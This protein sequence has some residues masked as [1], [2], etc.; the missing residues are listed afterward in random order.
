MARLIS[1]Q[2]AARLLDVHPQTV[3]NWV[4]KGIIKGHTVDKCLMVDRDTIEQYFDSLQDLAHLEKTVKE[5]TE[6]LREEDFN[7]QFEID[8]L[9]EAHDR[10]KDGPRGYYRWVSQYATMSAHGLF[11]GQQ[12]TIFHKMMNMGSAELVAKELGISRSRVVDIF[13]KCL[14]KISDVINLQEAQEKWDKLEQE[15][16]QLK[17]LNASLKQ[18]LDDLRIAVASMPSFQPMS[19]CEQI[20]KILDTPLGNFNFTQRS[21]NILKSF[22]CKTLGDVIC[23]TRERL[24]SA[25]NCGRK[26][27]DDIEKVLADNGYALG[28]DLNFLLQNA[29][30]E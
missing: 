14:R 23:L 18:Q 20:N 17:V 26:T 25:N 7:L 5:K 3:T 19:E 12:K 8:D 22:G 2:E 16:K 29:D 6:Y 27:V 10:I 4:S 30:K 9:L 21:V 11:T 24:M 1:R 13:F 28:V 15:N